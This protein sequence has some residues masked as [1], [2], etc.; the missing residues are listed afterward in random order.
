MLIPTDP[1]SRAYA[2]WTGALYLL[3]AVSGGFAIA[4]VP[5]VLHV[6]GD[7]QATLSQITAQRGL[8]LAGIGGDTVM[9]L[10]EVMVTAMLFFKFRNVHPT[11]ALAAAL[12]RFAMVAV[13]AGMLF[14]HAGL[15]ALADPDS[16]FGAFSPPEREALAYLMLTMHD[17][18][19][20][21]WQI[22]F[23]AHLVL[24]GRLVAHSGMYPRL[25][26]H[27]LTLG[28]LGYILDSAYSFAFP[29]THWL[30]TIR[31]GLLVLVTA[32]EIGFA[33]WLLFVGP[34]GPIEPQ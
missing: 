10:A 1:H 21:V 14:F 11:L 3:I 31:I 16:A 12:A 25:L 19:V 23:T 33:L 6:P 2:T 34:K 8:F 22:F 20:W 30:G 13:M 17:A 26:G 7:P 24:L 18:G 9:I 29:E 32:A 4:Y 15:L 5:S 27:A 28:G